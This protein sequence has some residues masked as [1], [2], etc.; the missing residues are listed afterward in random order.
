M[1]TV[2]YNDMTCGPC[3]CSDEYRE[4]WDEE[5][6]LAQIHHMVSNM[7]GMVRDM[8][9]CMSQQWGCPTDHMPCPGHMPMPPMQ[10]MPPM[11]PMPPTQP[12]PPPTYT[13][14]GLGVTP[15]PTCPGL[16]GTPLAPMPPMQ[17]MP[18]MMPAPMP[19]CAPIPGPMNPCPGTPLLG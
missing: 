16:G 19:P 18:P 14:P 9:E 8:K 1:A 12:M 17:P 4:E 11:E 10:P 7:C 15:L 3:N 13:C 2:S 5:R 6:K